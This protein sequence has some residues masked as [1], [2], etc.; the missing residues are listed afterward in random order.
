[1]A[2]IDSKFGVYRPAQKAVLIYSV[3][4]SISAIN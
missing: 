1:M 2:I 3:S 4:L